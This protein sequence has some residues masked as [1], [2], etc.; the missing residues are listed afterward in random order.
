MIDL[1]NFKT[2]NDSHGHLAGDRVLKGVAL[3]IKATLRGSDFL[4]RYG[5]DEYALILIKSDIKTATEVAWKLCEEVRGSRFILDDVTLPMTL[6]IGVA[7]A[8]ENDTD[9]ELL[10]RA[11]EALYCAKAAGRNGVAVADI[12]PLPE[13]RVT[14]IEVS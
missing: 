11:D 14:N 10:K 4:A 9:E 2:I 12:Q 7:E 1:D 6:S 13:S 3:K 5:G 8:T